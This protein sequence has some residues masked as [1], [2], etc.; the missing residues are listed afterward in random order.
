M[1]TTAF[2][3]THITLLRAMLPHTCDSDCRQLTSHAHM[4]QLYINTRQA[5]ATQGVAFNQATPYKQHTALPSSSI[6]SSSYSSSSSSSSSTLLLLC[7]RR[8][9]LLISLFYSITSPSS[10]PFA[11]IAAAAS[12]AAATWR[13]ALL[14]S[15]S[16]RV[17]AA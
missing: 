10:P 11:P 9:L 8:L 13:L 5:T 17:Q 7:L 2:I 16:S 1:F 4:F 15:A 12:A 6:I 3:E 14:H